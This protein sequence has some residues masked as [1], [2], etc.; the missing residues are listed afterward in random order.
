MSMQNK[1]CPSSEQFNHILLFYFEGHIPK[2][3]ANDVL[4][5][6]CSIKHWILFIM[7]PETLL[8]SQLLYF[9]ANQLLT[10]FTKRYKYLKRNQMWQG[11][12][13]IDKWFLKQDIFCHTLMQTNI[14]N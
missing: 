13:K 4:P 9:N 7:P 1:E 10:I 3:I 14:L 11:I 5:H 8:Y 2:D 6:F 12:G